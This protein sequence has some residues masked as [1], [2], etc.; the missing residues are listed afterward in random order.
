MSGTKARKRKPIS[1]AR[2][3]LDL[4]FVDEATYRKFESVTFG[5]RSQSICDR[6]WVSA[7]WEYPEPDRGGIEAKFQ[8][9]HTCRNDGAYRGD[10]VRFFRAVCNAAGIRDS[11]AGLVDATLLSRKNFDEPAPT[12]TPALTPTLGTPPVPDAWRTARNSDGD[13]IEHVMNILA[14]DD[15]W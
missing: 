11:E 10:S 5:R 6:K 4:W 14:F 7:H 8:F 3:E 13:G 15:E 12:P 9:T 1:A 2:I